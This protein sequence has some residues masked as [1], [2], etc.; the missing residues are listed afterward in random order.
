MGPCSMP[1]IRPVAR[2]AL[3]LL[4]A[5]RWP[6]AGGWLAAVCSRTQGIEGIS[7]VDGM[8]KMRSTSRKLLAAAHPSWPS[9]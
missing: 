9:P 4:V 2:Y 6:L 8:R 3:R 5:G 1:C 7:T